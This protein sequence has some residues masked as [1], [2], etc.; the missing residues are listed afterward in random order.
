MQRYDLVSKFLGY[1]T[2]PDQTN[3]DPRYLVDG[4]YNTLIDDAGRV[5]PRGGYKLDGAEDATVAG[6]DDSHDWL[7]S[8]GILLPIRGG[9][10]KLEVRISGAWETLASSLSSTDLSFAAWWDNTRKFDLLIIVDGT[11]TAR[12]WTGA[13]GTLAQ[14]DDATH[15]TINEDIGVARFASSGTIR[16]KDSSGTWREA[17]YT[18]ESGS[19]FTVTTDLMS[20]TFDADAL[21]L[22]STTAVSNFPASEFSS[23]FLAIV[24]NQVVVGSRT[25]RLLYISKSSDYADF[26]FSSPRV[27]GDGEILTMDGVGRAAAAIEDTLF[28]S[29]GTDD[30]YRIE[31]EQISVGSTLSETARIKKLKTGAGQAALHHNLVAPIGNAIAFISNDQ[32]FRTLGYEENFPDVQMSSLST[33]IKPDFDTEDFTGGHI[34]P[35]KNRIYITA[36]ANSRVWINEV[37]EDENGVQ[38][39]FWQP[40]QV[41]PFSRM[42]IIDGDLY[43]HGNATPESYKVFEG[44]SDRLD[45]D[46]GGEEARPISAEA[47]FAYRTFGA[48]DLYKAFELYR[49]EGYIAA[50]TTLSLEINYDYGGASGQIV[51]M[52]SGLDA[53][54]RFLPQSNNALGDY[55]LGEVPLG[56]EE[57]LVD[58][59]KFF[60]DHEESPRDCFELQASYS[61]SGK[62]QRWK[63]LAHGPAILPSRNQPT[64][65][66]Q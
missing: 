5:G 3:T 10:G 6:I 48:R 63:L 59:A 19:Q 46:G 20:Y 18:S 11:S 8:S 55:A 50:N 2:K 33:A 25:S 12:T 40:P 60:V 32:Q 16:V 13:K 57:E 64:S 37:T 31:F 36:P 66:R 54:I 56:V 39:R 9:N 65:I 14:V 4:S 29:A 49:S 38:R 24:R 35:H 7:N 30:W 44:Y 41:F 61:S 53:A 17:V 34:K 45:A 27:P 22:Q 1:V 58:L 52:I 51:E 47:R 15:V 26:T 23:D 42:S 28:A 21:V 62:D 43:A